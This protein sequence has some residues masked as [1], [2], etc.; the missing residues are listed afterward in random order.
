MER[1]SPSDV[2]TA[3]VRSLA[4]VLPAHAVFAERT[5]AWLWGVDASSMGVGRADR[6]IE[7]AVPA[8]RASP[9]IPG[10]RTRGGHLPAED[11]T[12]LDG[13]RV[14]TRERTA[15]DCAR[16]LPRLEAIAA[17]D[18]FLRAGTDAA[19]LRRRM[20]LLT[21][22]THARRLREVLTLADAG[23][24]LPGETYTRIRVMDAGLPRPRTQIP[25][26]SSG[27]PRFFLDMGYED[28]LTAVE[29]DG[30]EF[31]TARAHC[32]RDAARR[33]WIREHHGWEIIVVTKEDVLFNPAPFL[34][35]LTTIL[36]HRGWSPAPA[37]LDRIAAKLT[38][39][40][41]HRPP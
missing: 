33:T 27:R 23:A 21:G 18:Q 10:C 26:P 5:A 16:W 14:T 36:M 12:Y 39:L 22:E 13:V 11:V 37:R 3:R 35:T 6:P 25:V 40:R 28:H 4:S 29:Y 7:L 32:R 38:R 30:E 17:L 41:R 19:L 8:G 24:M 2:L 9:D 15:L 1:P 31:H 20:R 34:E